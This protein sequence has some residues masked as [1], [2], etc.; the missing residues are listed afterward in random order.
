VALTAVAVATMLVLTVVAPWLPGS[1][2][3]E[4]M[5]GGVS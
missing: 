2:V 4:S 5:L 3:V 1:E